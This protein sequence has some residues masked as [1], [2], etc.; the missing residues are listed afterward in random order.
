MHVRESLCIKWTPPLAL[1]LLY[2]QCPARSLGRLSAMQSGQL[3]EGWLDCVTDDP[4]ESAPPSSAASAATA[5]THASASFSP[6]TM[7]ASLLQT[8]PAGLI[9]LLALLLLFD[10]V[11]YF[12]WDSEVFDLSRG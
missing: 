3:T 2:G 7:V 10:L 1:L 9:C 11:D 4:S 5:A 6:A 12:V 8:S